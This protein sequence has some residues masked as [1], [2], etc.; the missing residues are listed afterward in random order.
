M[1]TSTNS[2]D[3]LSSL[4]PEPPDSPS[5]IHSPTNPLSPNSLASPIEAPLSSSCSSSL[6]SASTDDDDDD[7]SSDMPGQYRGRGGFPG[8]PTRRK[9]MEPPPPDLSTLLTVP[10]KPELVALVTN[11]INKMKA[12]ITDAFDPT[13]SGDW[14]DATTT[15]GNTRRKSWDLLEDNPE[16]KALRVE[17]QSKQQITQSLTADIAGTTS[18]GSD[19]E[20]VQILKSSDQQRSNGVTDGAT[21]QSELQKEALVHF[22]KWE[23][24]ILRRVNE[25]VVTTAD[26]QP[27]SGSSQ[28][29]TA[30]SA[31]A[32]EHL[33]R[34]PDAPKT[35]VDM[36]DRVL[37]MIFPPTPTPLYQLAM[38]KR[39]LLLH[40]MLLL[41]LS[42]G[43]YGAYSRVFLLHLAT[44][45][46]VPLHVLEEDETRIA[47]ALALTT[48]AITRDDALA[49]RAEDAKKAKNG[50]RRLPSCQPAQNPS[51]A[52]AL[53]GPLIEAGMGAVF[54]G[55]A[56]PKTSTVALLH[57]MSDHP[58]VI[59]VLFG[60]YGARGHG[61]M[62][63]SYVKDIH[64]L[65]F[66]PLCSSPAAAFQD[67]T[68]IEPQERRMRVSICISGW[69]SRK[70]ADVASPWRILGRQS[71][72]WALRWDADA[73][74]KVGNA[75]EAV[76]RSPIWAKIKKQVASG[77]GSAGLASG[78]WPANMLKISKIVDNPWSVGL[79]RAEKAAGVLLESLTNRIQGERGVTL[80]GYGLG[81]RIIYTC[82]MSLAER[83]MFGIVENVVLMGAPVPSDPKVWAKMR[84]VVAGRVVNVYSENDYIL[85]FL[86]RTASY[87]FGAAGMKRIDGVAGV[88]NMDASGIVD[89]HL[90]YRYLAGSILKGLGWEDIA[91]NQAASDGK[92]V[93]VIEAQL[94]DNE[95]SR[96]PQPKAVAEEKKKDVLQPAV[97]MITGMGFGKKKKKAKS[98]KKAEKMAAR[99]QMKAPG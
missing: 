85:G 86:Y 15:T 98:Q 34:D 43:H 4:S 32:A 28:K 42:L 88:E 18:Y 83:R 57:Q 53:A 96:K 44:T 70:D 77:A 45:F 84:C 31:R 2:F 29:A 33:R 39:T 89:Y 76:S 81:A 64:D 11:I 58:Y 95:R 66:F 71:E 48:A 97:P 79:V 26:R 41:V 54:G 19:D 91:L 59:G 67:A 94:A 65:A 22:S 20:P 8:G 12:Q 74:T 63:E 51:R 82:L 68:D 90:Q 46:R 6:S 36:A 7:S 21:T 16:M 75:L 62:M 55:V 69:N 14:I 92:M 93:G 24:A 60:L 35:S 50:G 78:Q 87:Q 3:A 61:K 5:T 25:I 37:P 13:A 99:Q 23:T 27:G 9:P 47:K 38:N 17:L 10:Q 1:I 56:V 73:L 30:A 40:V 80:I 52:P 72:V 49:W